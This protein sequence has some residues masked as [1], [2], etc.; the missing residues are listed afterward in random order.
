MYNSCKDIHFNVGTVNASMLNR[1]QLP[2]FSRELY[3]RAHMRTIGK[4]NISDDVGLT[5]EVPTDDIGNDTFWPH[6]LR[7]GGCCPFPAV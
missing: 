2:P 6:P 1:H 4:V 3:Y 5:T 7:P